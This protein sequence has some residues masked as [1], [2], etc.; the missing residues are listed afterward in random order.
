[1]TP[2]LPGLVLTPT[3]AMRAGTQQVWQH[4]Q[5]GTVVVTPQTSPGRSLNRCPNPN[6][7]RPEAAWWRQQLPVAGLSSALAPAC[8]CYLDCRDCSLTGEWHV[9]PGE[10]CAAH[11][12]APG[13]HDTP[14]EEQPS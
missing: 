5:C 14:E 13:D 3:P 4:S 8:V 9:H 6:C 12:E 11:P 1:M 10:P 2:D 7:T